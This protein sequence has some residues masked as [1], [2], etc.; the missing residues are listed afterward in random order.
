MRVRSVKSE[1]TK[2]T[3]H[4][5]T[6]PIRMSNSSRGIQHNPSPTTSIQS[7]LV[8]ETSVVSNVQRTSKILKLT[9]NSRKRK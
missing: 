6:M 1:F 9:V 2:S 4:C 8:D 3:N 5:D 7:S